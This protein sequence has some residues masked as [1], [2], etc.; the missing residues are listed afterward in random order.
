MNKKGGAGIVVVII[1][2]IISLILSIYSIIS[3]SSAK[4]SVDSLRKE[5][6]SLPIVTYED[7]NKCRSFENDEDGTFNCNQICEE[8]GL[9]C[10]KADIAYYSGVVNRWIVDTGDECGA[11]FAG[12][13]NEPSDGNH[14]LQCL[15]CG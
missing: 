6:N 10:V 9:I 5:I 8:Q 14:K 1:L 2:V 12:L 11:G 4:D 15:C 7:L 3:S 13:K